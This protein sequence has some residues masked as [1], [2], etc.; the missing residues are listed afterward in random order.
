M[1]NSGINLDINFDRVLPSG[2]V[3]MILAG[4]ILVLSVLIVLTI[5][6]FKRWK[7]RFL[8]LAAGLL[9]YAV[10]VFMFSEMFMS[11][12]RLVPA[13]D[14][15]FAYNPSSYVMVYNLAFIAG[16]GI[17]RWFLVKLIFGRYDREGDIYIAGVGMAIG[18]G[19]MG[20]GLSILSSYVYAQA[21]TSNGLEEALNGLVEGGYSADQV[22]EQYNAFIDP[23]F[24][25][26]EV[27][28]LI[29][30]VSAVLDIV[31]N[32]LLVIVVYGVAK[33]QVNYMFAWYG[34]VVQFVTN[35][36]FQVYNPA[37]LTNILILFTAKLV[38]V[39]ALGFFV[40]RFVMKE[41]SYSND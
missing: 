34:M 19:I 11:I 24:T 40:Q 32:I 38:I 29:L 13:V 14:Q 3:N 15:S 39:A 35:I 36:L 30:G 28:W 9:S 17:A 4:A 23:L 21:I 8:P 2:T 20:Y 41:I 31:V 22:V 5:V 6:I 7:G 25:A 26:P 33:K 27:L 1:E 16:L 37:S 18:N 12:I 10:F